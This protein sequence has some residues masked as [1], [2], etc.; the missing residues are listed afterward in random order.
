MATSKRDYYEVLG[1]P[2][3]A[4]EDDI[5]RAF[6]KLA[7]DH[8]PDRN[9]TPTHPIAS[10]KSTRRTRS[11]ETPKSAA[12]TIALGTPAWIPPS[13]AGL[14]ADSVASA[15]T[16]SSTRSSAARAALARPRAQ[17]GADL[18][19]DISMTVRGGH[20]RGR[21]GDPGP[22]AR[23]LPRAAVLGS[24]PGRN[25]RPAPAVAEVGSFAA[26]IS[27]SLASSSTSV[28]AIRALAKDVSSAHRAMR[29]TA[30]GAFR[31]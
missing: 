5:R 15:S 3:G 1:V 31:R 7:F 18:R 28:S 21:E 26:P 16:T 11:F 20:L 13:T 8:H 24:S 30:P 14:A 27:R 10:K 25:P 23:V 22:E 6:R 9:T 17:R 19:T 4:T 29:A 2:K 12:P